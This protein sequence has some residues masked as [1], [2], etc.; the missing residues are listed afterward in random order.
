MSITLSTVASESTFSAV[1][2]VLDQFHSSLTPNLVE[3]LICAQEWL[4]ASPLSIE[5][6][7]N[8]EE[9]EKLESSIYLFNFS[10]N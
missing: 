4:R 3:S 5:V 2:W 10:L 1:G 7:E 9:V 6:V 8:L